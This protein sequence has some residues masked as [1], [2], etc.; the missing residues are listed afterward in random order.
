MLSPLSSLLLL[1]P[2]FGVVVQPW[3]VVFWVN[4]SWFFVCVFVHFLCCC[5]LLNVIIR[6]SLPLVA[7]QRFWGSNLCVLLV[8][9]IEIVIVEK[10]YIFP[11]FAWLLHPLCR[12]LIFVA[13]CSNVVL[14]AAAVAVAFVFKWCTWCFY[15]VVVVVSSVG[16]MPCLSS[17]ICRF[18]Y[19]LLALFQCV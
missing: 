18:V 11:C 7:C 12:V 3:F 9:A 5:W 13:S 6:K 10:N 16:S 19:Q 4:L 14:F 2:L 15:E 1:L 17:P 8:A